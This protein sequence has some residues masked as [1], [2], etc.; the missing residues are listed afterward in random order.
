[1]SPADRNLTIELALRA[2]VLVVIVAIAYGGYRWRKNFI[3]SFFVQGAG[4]AV[5]PPCLRQLACQYVDICKT[6]ESR[7]PLRL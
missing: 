3:R 2:A 6:V 5:C 7:S 1:M 4:G